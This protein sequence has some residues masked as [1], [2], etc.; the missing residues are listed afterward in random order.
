MANESYQQVIHLIFDGNIDRLLEIKNLREILKD[1]DSKGCTVLIAVAKVSCPHKRYSRCIEHI[2]KLGADPAAVDCNGDTAAHVA[3]RCGNLRILALL[4]FEAKF[5]TNGEN[6]TPL[7]EAVRN[8]RF[9]CAKHLL[10][11][12]RQKRYFHRKKE[13]LN[14]RNKKGK[15]ALALAKDSHHNGNIV[16]EMVEIISNEAK[17]SLSGDGKLRGLANK[18]QF[19]KMKRLAIEGNYTELQL[20]V[21][22]VNCDLPDETGR[23]VLSWAAESDIKPLEKK[24][25]TLHA[26]IQV[27]DPTAADVNGETSL[28]F[29]ALRSKMHAVKLLVEEGV[30]VNISDS[31]GQTPVMWAATSP[32]QVASTVLT[33]VSM[34]ADCTMVDSEGRT[35]LVLSKSSALNPALSTLMQTASGVS[36]DSSITERDAKTTAGM[37]KT[38]SQ[39]SLT[40]RIRNWNWRSNSSK[41]SSGVEDALR[42]SHLASSGLFQVFNICDY[43]DKSRYDQRVGSSSDVNALR[44]MATELSCEIEVFENQGHKEMK[45]QLKTLAKDSM[46]L[47]KHGWL[48]CVIMAHGNNGKIVVPDGKELQIKEIVDQFNSY[49]CSALQ[50]K[51]KVFIIQAC[52]GERMDVQRPTDSG[53]SGDRSSYSPVESDILIFYSATE[54]Y[55]SYRGNTEEEVSPFIQTLCKVITEY[56]RTEHLAD[57]LTI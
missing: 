5:L 54:G 12:F 55:A 46:R 36:P 37:R 47:E 56:H 27:G 10:H 20:V 4:P 35:A 30:P 33:M 31:E 15:T 22:R 43:E 8:C 44:K 34:G 39:L 29:A 25:Q 48:I 6:C 11:L 24:Q 49:H 14:I 32:S 1:K 7:M 2:L 38:E 23:T 41:R 3:A 53:P 51:P 19:E 28:H 18:S 16:Q 52:R 45:K 50:H 9:R 21:T 17:L 40:E 13:L 42:Y 26:L 57:M